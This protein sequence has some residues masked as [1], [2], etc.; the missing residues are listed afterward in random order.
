MTS[1]EAGKRGSIG[2]ADTFCSGV[3]QVALKVVAESC[4]TSSNEGANRCAAASVATANY[5]L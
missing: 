5:T 4:V 3:F 1:Q 2:V